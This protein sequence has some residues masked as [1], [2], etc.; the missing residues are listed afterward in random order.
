MWPGEGGAEKRQG[1][2]PGGIWKPREFSN[3]LQ[4]NSAEV[5]CQWVETSGFGWEGNTDH[6][7]LAVR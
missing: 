6:E 1:S 5:Q 3:F 4:K 2:P 7:G